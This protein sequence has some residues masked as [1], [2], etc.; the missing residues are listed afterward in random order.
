[1]RICYN[2]KGLFQKRVWKFINFSTSQIFREI[3]FV[4]IEFQEL[5]FNNSFSSSRSSFWKSLALSNFHIYPYL[6]SLGL[7]TCQIGHF[8][9]L[10]FPKLISR[11]IWVVEKCLKFHTEHNLAPKIFNIALFFTYYLSK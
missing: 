8:E 1:M 2:I 5:H 10:Y 4:S 3:N 6:Q 11:K 7:D 9:A